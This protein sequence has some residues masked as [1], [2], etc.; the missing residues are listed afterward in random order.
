[1]LELQVDQSIETLLIPC[2]ASWAWARTSKNS[3]MLDQVKPQTSSHWK[4]LR[5]TKYFQVKIHL[6]GKVVSE[7]WVAETT[8]PWK[9]ISPLIISIGTPMIVTCIV[10]HHRRIRY[11]Q[12]EAL[13]IEVHS[14]NKWTLSN[15]NSI[16]T[17][18]EIRA[19]G[20][21]R[22][23]RSTDSLRGKKECRNC[24]ETVL[25]NHPL[26]LQ[27]MVLQWRI[28]LRS[29]LLRNTMKVCQTY[30]SLLQWQETMTLTLMQWMRM[31]LRPKYKLESTSKR[32]FSS[33]QIR[34]SW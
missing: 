7:T 1:M 17:Q 10:R 21:R 2:Q 5:K 11:H 31:I 30:N 32:R 25:T 18:L 27:K 26:H 29:K 20:L 6:E 8:R 4:R 12:R 9:P 24:P 19:Q 28:I 13:E 33:L 23:K 34:E 14:L 3:W 15:R 16:L 22:R